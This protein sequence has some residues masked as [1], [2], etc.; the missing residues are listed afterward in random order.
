[1]KI[2]KAN[3]YAIYTDEELFSHLINLLIDE[4]IITLKD[5]EQKIAALEITSFNDLYNYA[6]GANCKQELAIAI[7]EIADRLRLAEPK[8]IASFTSSSELGSYLAHKLVGHKQE[9]FWVLY[10]NNSNRIIAEKKISQGTLDRAIVH[11]RDV[12][13]WAVLYNCSSI[14]IAHNHP[15][16]NLLPSSNDLKIT[17][18][19]EDAARLMK[20]NLLDHFILAKDNFLSMKEQELF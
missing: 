10:L 6:S 20:I 18:Q 3:H 4:G 2:L 9:E 12:F 7:E 5:L 15:S 17:K 16:G 19:L 14:V 11:P 1:M 13:R 8:R